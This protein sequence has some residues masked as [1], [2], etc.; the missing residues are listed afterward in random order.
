LL[1]ASTRGS[2]LQLISTAIPLIEVKPE[3]GMAFFEAFE[4]VDRFLQR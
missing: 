2:A 3:L 1:E 4:W